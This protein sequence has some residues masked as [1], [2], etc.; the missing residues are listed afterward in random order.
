MDSRPQGTNRPRYSANYNGGNSNNNNNNNN[1]YQ[2]G[3]SRSGGD[4]GN[5]R[6]GSG[7]GSNRGRS[8]FYSDRSAPRREVHFNNATQGK[9]GFEGG[10]RAKPHGIFTNSR[11]GTRFRSRESEPVD[12]WYLVEIPHGET[13]GKEALLRSLNASMDSPVNPIN[14]RVDGNQVSFHIEGQDTADTLKRLNKR[15]TKAD[16]YK[17]TI[18]VKPSAP[19]PSTMDE[20]T[21]ELIK[22]VMSRRFSTERNFLDLSKF[23][24]DE[25]FVKKELYVSLDRLPVI[26]AVVKII[27]ENIPALAMLDVSENRIR[28]LKGLSPLKDVCISLRALNLSKNSI[29]TLT[30]LDHLNGLNL[31]EICLS[32]NPAA[33]VKDTSSLISIVRKNFPQ[34]KKMDGQDLPASIGFDVGQTATRAPATLGSHVPENVAPVLDS[35]LLK[36][37]TA[38]DSDDRRPLLELYHDHAVFS[39]SC[40]NSANFPREMIHE[41]RN[42]LRISDPEHKRRIL[43]RGNLNIV[44][45][46]TSFCKTSHIKD[47][48]TL[49]VCFASPELISVMITGLFIE[50]SQRQRTIRAFSRTFNLVPD[51]K[52]GCVIINDVWVISNSSYDQ[53]QKSR[54]FTSS[55]QSSSM[56]DDQM[57]SETFASGDNSSPVSSE[58]ALVKKLSD[59]TGMN[60]NYSRQ[61]LSE[62][63]FDYDQAYQIFLQVNALGSIPPEAFN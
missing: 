46:L 4:R 40:F 52:S 8:N 57:S 53:R 16:G 9:R 31:E 10:S 37:F 23:R 42:L 63:K 36:Y 20:T 43:K 6:R 2:S 56:Q 30:E 59:V 54:E 15:I 13:G 50:P 3:H 41:S 25:E 17:I 19:P 60:K 34:L 62:V 32:E 38:F 26:Q 21:T 27:Q 45:S 29:A 22:Q 55:Q 1:N 11:S 24:K 18:N 12:S 51:E 7:R 28:F 14:Y 5:S 35:F 39:Y 58:E 44:A 33:K 47:S 48:F 61:C 49:D